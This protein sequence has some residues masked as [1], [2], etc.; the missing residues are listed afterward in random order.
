MG[1]TIDVTTLCPVNAS[2]RKA[3]GFAKAS[4]SVIERPEINASA[5]RCAPRDGLTTEGFYAVPLP[6]R[7]EALS[8]P[9][10]HQGQKIRIVR[11]EFGDTVNGS[12]T[13]VSSLS[14]Y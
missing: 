2:E 14:S 7:D 5:L 8:L 10:C 4:S 6:D 3:K 1:F 13:L 12:A 9:M 11:S